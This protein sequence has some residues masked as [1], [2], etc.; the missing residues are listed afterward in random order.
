MHA[1]FGVPLAQMA[2]QM[3]I[4]LTMFLL[5]LSAIAGGVSGVLL[6]LSAAIR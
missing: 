6:L 3:A 1:A 5:A 4:S 2:T